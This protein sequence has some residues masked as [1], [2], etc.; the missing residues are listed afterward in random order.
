MNINEIRD[1][2]AGGYNSHEYVNRAGNMIVSVPIADGA[3]SLTAR[4]Y[5]TSHDGALPGPGQRYL[6]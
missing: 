5:I 1:C 3:L 2:V 6:I 4:M